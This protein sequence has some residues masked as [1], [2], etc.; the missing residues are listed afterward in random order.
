MS[1]YKKL[2]KNSVIFA[3]ANLGTKIMTVLL[4]PFYTYVLSTEQYGTVD[5]IIT[6]ISLLL[7]VVSLSIFDSV[8]RFGM[9]RRYKKNTI[10]TS[11]IIIMII[12][13][14]ISMIFIPIISFVEDVSSYILLFY[15]ILIAQGLNSIFSQFVR[16]NGDIK[17]FAANGVLNTFITL[18]FNIILLVGYDM[19]ISGYLISILIANIISCIFLII[20][21]KIYKYFRLKYYSASITKEMLK[22]S[23]PLIPN[24]LMWWIMNV[25][26]RYVITMVLGISANGIYAVANKIPSLLNILNSIFF[27]AWQMSAIEEGNSEKKDEFF[28]NVFNTFASIMLIGTSLILV[29]IKFVIN[30]FLSVDF[31]DAWKFVPFLLLGVVFSSFSGFLGTNYIAMKK[32]S[33]V[34]KTSIIGAAINIILNIVFVPLI[35]MNAAAIS[36]MISFLIVWILR[37]HDTKNFVNI[38]LDIKGIL[39]ML[40]IISIQIIVLY[41]N[42]KYEVLIQTMFFII[43]IVINY[44][45]IRLL[46]KNRMNNIK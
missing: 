24:S 35:G 9:D 7:P 18:F 22:Y 33:G 11:S 34:F 2:F 45:N 40:I 42:I 16:A 36:T 23:I 37:I 20:C 6:T 21:G 46:L 26:D 1:K 31:R 8:L 13:F 27:Q 19:G 39:I 32:T 38:K 17:L 3:I 41:S 12:G 5:M 14:T 43:I 29:V 4:V 44:T 10:L 28:S 30:I 25:S 15:L